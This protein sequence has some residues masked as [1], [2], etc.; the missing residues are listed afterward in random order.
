M[1]NFTLS[2]DVFIRAAEQFPTPFHIY[3]EA[4]IRKTAQAVNAAFSWAPDFKEYFAVKAL[5][6]PAI[7]K[8]Y[9]DEGCGLDC[10]SECELLLAEMSGF[11][12]EEIMFSAN[13]MPPEEFDHARALG[14]IVNLDDISDID[15]LAAHGGIPETVCIR[16]NPGGD[17]T[18]G[19]AIMGSPGESKYGWTKEQVPAGLSR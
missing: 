6:N 8:I 1:P 10:S 7:L 19:N 3:D 12:G 13:A 2:D 4:G 11:R 9:K 17:F 16:Y 15:I 18:L 14:A 5:P